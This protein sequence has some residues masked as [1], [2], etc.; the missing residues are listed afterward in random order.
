MEDSF[1]ATIQI[2]QPP[3]VVFARL[4]DVSRWWGGA[5][6]A[7][8]TAEVGDTFTV[9]HGDAHYS[10]QRVMEVVPDSRIVWLVTESKLNWLEKDKSEWTGTQ[11]I[12]E[13]TAEDEL[14]RLRFTHE[15]L[16][17]SKECYARCA[18][19]WT[20]VIAEWLSDFITKNKPRF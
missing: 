9:I 17:R 12:F 5:D 3:P 18:E 2:S 13:I 6:L 20:M 7:G 19:G 15:G 11:M 8:R 16:T 10:K 14:T 4:K 1:T